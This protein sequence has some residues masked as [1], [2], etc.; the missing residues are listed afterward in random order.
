MT[1]PESARSY[2]SRVVIAAYT[3]ACGTLWLY[4]LPVVL[5]SVASLCGQRRDLRQGETEQTQLFSALYSGRV[6]HSRFRPVKHTFQYP[7]FLFC[8]DL[9]EVQ[10]GLL[11]N[12]LWPLSCICQLREADHLKNGEGGKCNKPL[13]DRIISLVEEKT[14]ERFEK[15]HHRVLL[16]TH[17]SYFG[18]CFNPVSFY[19]IQNISNH[20]IQAVVGEV[21]NTPWN[22]M[23]CYVLHAKSTDHVQVDRSTK[24]I[25]RYV[26]PKQFHV[27]PFME[28]DYEYDWVF[29][30]IS[31]QSSIVISNSLRRGSAMQFYA[32]MD[33]ERHSLHPF[34][35]AWHLSTYPVYC[36]IIQVWIH[37]QAFWLFLKGVP[38]QPHP[39][40]SETT[41][42]RLIG[43]IMTP[44]FV[45]QDWWKGVEHQN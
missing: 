19:I 9:A 15:T 2:D 42:S 16:I 34:R 1:M 20:K 7:L 35:I 6:W 41:A 21:S 10:Q 36:A 45:I 39:K 22:E 25:H 37:Y 30:D 14:G 29:R 11:S 43:R 32:K 38:Y 18:Y 23:H 28:M 24:D 12:I 17:L 27:S 40:G 44:F 31:P 26:F 13:M 8:L 5:A 33:V 3:C 4:G